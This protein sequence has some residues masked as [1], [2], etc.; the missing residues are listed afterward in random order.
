[1]YYFLPLLS[2]CYSFFCLSVASI[3]TTMQFKNSIQPL[4]KQTARTGAEL[5]SLGESSTGIFDLKELPY[6]NPLLVTSNAGIGAKLN[7]AQSFN[8]H[9]SIGQDLVAVCLNEIVSRGAEPLFFLNYFATARLSIKDGIQ[10]IRGIV[11]ACKESN[12][13]LLANET[14]EM[15]GPYQGNEYNLAGFAVG[16]VER[17]NLVPQKELI[18]NGDVIIGLPSSGLHTTGFEII[19]RI[20]AENNLDISAPPPYFSTHKT[21]ADSLLEPTIAYTNYLLPLCKQHL[22]KAAMPTTGGLSS[23]ISCMI[24][25]KMAAHIDMNLWHVPTMFRWFAYMADLSAHQLAE[26]FNCGIG[27]ALIADEQNAQTIQ[28]ELRAQGLPSMVVGKVSH[29]IN[30]ASVILQGSISQEPLK[31]LIL[32]SDIQE[33]T[34]ANQLAQSAYVGLILM[35]PGSHNQPT[36]P[37]I[38]NVPISLFH[39][40]ALF[41]YAKQ[42]KI[43]LVIACSNNSDEINALFEKSHANGLHCLEYKSKVLI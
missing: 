12:C 1:M 32:G 13:A 21:F 19:R 6:T 41:T 38:R 22:I 27:M 28:N 15:P 39:T 14:A 16:I 42:N 23:S 36:H 17:E 34:L 31:I 8:Q 37:K 18:K 35:A 26:K 10:L 25:E 29:K 9:N 43:T 5:H 33:Q 4:L 20:I 3:S 7:M 11:N 2:V 30:N 40:N 24:P